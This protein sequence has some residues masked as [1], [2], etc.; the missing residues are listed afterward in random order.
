MS[1]PSALPAVLQQPIQTAVDVERFFREAA[2]WE[3]IKWGTERVEGLLALLNHPEQHLR[4]IIVGGTNGKGSTA[5]TLGLLLQGL[6]LR[7][8]VNLSPHVTYLNERIQPDLAPVPM[9]QLI[10]V[11]ETIRQALLQWPDPA[12]LPTYHELWTVAAILVF[13]QSGMEWGILEVGM[14]GRYDAARAVPAQIAIITP[15]SFDHMEFL[16]HTLTAIATEKAEIIAPGGLII[17]A[18]QEPEAAAVIAAKVE[19]AGARWLALEREILLETSPAGPVLPSGDRYCRQGSEFQ[20]VP[21]LRGR[22]QGI[23]AATALL[24]LEGMLERGWL[25]PGLDSPCA[26]ALAHLKRAGQRLVHPARFERLSGTPPV[27]CEGGHNPAALQV[28]VEDFA[29][30][31]QE[32]PLH[33]LVGFK[34]GKAVADALRELARLNPERLIATESWQMKP[35]PAQDIAAAASQLLPDCTVTAEPDLSAAM[36]GWLTGIQQTA[37]ASGLVIGSLYLCGDVRR[38]LIEDQLGP[39]PWSI[40]LEPHLRTAQPWVET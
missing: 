24:A 1:T 17:T 12:Q 5:L 14:G 11:M 30:L 34:Q 9:G 29:P 26:A 8:G 18:P 21:A 22:Y 20:L 31:T 37:G 35:V 10:E 7:V 19:S 4:W 3:K 15:I 25:T 28:F 27:W 39:G 40:S 38:V 6:G 36:R 33:I 2:P 13:S 23:N 32:H 16:G